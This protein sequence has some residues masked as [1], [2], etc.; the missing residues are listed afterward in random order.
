MFDW[1]N[2]VIKNDIGAATVFHMVRQGLVRRPADW[3]D[4]SDLTDAA[5]QRLAAAPSERQKSK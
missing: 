5:R 1:D 3:G 2:T 4:F